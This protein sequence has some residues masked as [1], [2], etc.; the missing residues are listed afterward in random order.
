MSKGFTRTAA[1]I[2][3][4]SLLLFA[5]GASANAGKEFRINTTINY[6][7]TSPKTQTLSDGTVVVV[8]KGKAA[9]S[10][11]EQLYGQRLDAKGH[12]IGEEFLVSSPLSQTSEHAIISFNDGSFVVVWISYSKGLFGQRFSPSGAKLGDE[13]AIK[14]IASHEGT[15]EN[16][17]IATIKGDHFVVVWDYGIT[18]S[19]TDVLRSDL[20]KADRRKA[21]RFASTNPLP[22]LNTIRQSPRSRMARLSSSGRRTRYPTF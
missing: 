14:A 19:P 17:S 3:L 13:F 2:G 22:S 5:S 21:S 9:K 8:W 6:Y 1:A 15:P 4:S 12:K 7:E 20:A 11:D 10:W 18:G 16:I